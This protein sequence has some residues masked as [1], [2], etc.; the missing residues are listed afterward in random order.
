VAVSEN[1]THSNEEIPEADLLDQQSPLDPNPLTDTPADLVP[2]P[3][4]PVVDEA[5]RLDQLAVVPEQGEDDY[6]HE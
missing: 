2:D 4:A 6:P 3:S 1:R 5:D